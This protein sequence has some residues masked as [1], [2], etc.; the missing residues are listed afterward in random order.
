MGSII[1]NMSM[2][3]FLFH[4]PGWNGLLISLGN[5]CYWV[6]ALLPYLVQWFISKFLENTVA[7]EEGSGISIGARQVSVHEY[8]TALQ[9][10]LL[11]YGIVGAC[12]I[13]VPIFWFA[14]PSQ[15]EYYQAQ[16]VLGV[17]MPR[18]RG[19]NWFAKS[20]RDMKMAWRGLTNDREYVTGHIFVV[21][22]STMDS[23]GTFV[24][25]A[26]PQPYGTALFNTEEGGDDLAKL[27][28]ISLVVLGCTVAPVSGVVIDKAGVDGS[29]VGGIRYIAYANGVGI[30]FVALC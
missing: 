2:F 28:T 21:G 19:Q 1:N 8:V 16:D 9:I 5:S 24:Y 26:M 10:A 23:L 7:L 17:P 20:I 14:V 13:S 22:A 12:A 4:L 18:P 30:L 29:R 6:S 15:K 25:Q 3:A 11:I 27:V